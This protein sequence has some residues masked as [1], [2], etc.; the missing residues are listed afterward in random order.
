M[1][2]M[3]IGSPMTHFSITRGLRRGDALSPFL[4]NIVA[5]GLS[6][7]LQKA[8]DLDMMYGEDFG[9]KR[10][11]VPYLQ[12]A[13][14]MII[15]AKPNVVFLHNIKRILRCFEL[16]SGLKVNFFESC[17][18]RVGKKVEQDTVLAKTLYCKSASLSITYLGLTLGAHPSSKAFWNSVIEKIQNRLT[19]WKRKFLTK[20]DMLVL[21][22]SVL[23]SIPTFFMAISKISVSIAQIIEKLQMRFL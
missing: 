5:E 9:G 20:G 17:V 8:N 19:P 22:K 16:A 18:V 23:S 6:C 4:F 10:I 21:I 11:H 13:D 7:S 3:I 14:A 1:S 12:F 2:V 15:F